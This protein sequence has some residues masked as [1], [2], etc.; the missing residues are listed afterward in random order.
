[1]SCHAPTK[2]RYPDKAGLSLLDAGNHIGRSVT[3]ASI[4]HADQRVVDRLE[5]QPHIECGASVAADVLPVGAAFQHSTGKT[6]AVETP[7]GTEPTRR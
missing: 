2:L 3:D 7:L 5:H 1:M 4:G 6:F